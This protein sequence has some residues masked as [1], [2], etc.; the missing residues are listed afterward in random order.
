ML[1][2]VALLPNA[3]SVLIEM[4]TQIRVM[5]QASSD[6]L[7][8]LVYC[9]CLSSVADERTLG[10]MDKASQ[11][12]FSL[13]LSI[14]GYIGRIRHPPLTL[15]ELSKFSEHVRV[16]QEFL[17][18]RAAS[19]NQHAATA[20][21]VSV[22]ANFLK[23][24][25]LDAGRLLGGYFIQPDQFINFFYA[26]RLFIECLDVAITGRRGE[27]LKELLHFDVDDL[28]RVESLVKR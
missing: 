1:Y 12:L 3:D 15:G 14:E 6:V 16:L 2:T 18:S 23:S 22:A 17:R 10:R 27:F 9:F 13:K 19:R 20:G 28:R 7:V 25:P 5:R 4:K 24:D 8:F 26:C 11:E 21:V